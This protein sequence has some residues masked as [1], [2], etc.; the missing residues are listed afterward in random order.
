MEQGSEAGE[1]DSVATVNRRL[2]Q[3]S[4][5]IRIISKLINI[6]NRVYLRCP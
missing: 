5:S 3:S 4:N 2:T 1:G 6:R